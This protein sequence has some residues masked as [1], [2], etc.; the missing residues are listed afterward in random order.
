M[1]KKKEIS[2]FIR[3]HLGALDAAL[4]FDIE[5]DPTGATY[6]LMVNATKIG[7]IQ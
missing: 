3:D 4:F 6:T 5:N 1:K 2:K 7:W